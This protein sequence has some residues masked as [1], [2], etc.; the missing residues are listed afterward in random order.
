MYTLVSREYNIPFFLTKLITPRTKIASYLW[1]QLWNID[2]KAAHPH[3][4]NNVFSPDG[5]MMLCSDQLIPLP[6]TK[7]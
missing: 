2:I 1:G 5:P 7:I 3:A 4:Y 6:H